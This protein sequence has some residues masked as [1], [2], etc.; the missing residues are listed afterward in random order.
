MSVTPFEGVRAGTGAKAGV[1]EGRKRAP[2][3]N[4]TP[5]AAAAATAAKPTGKER[6]PLLEVTDLDVAYGQVVAIR[7]L[8]MSVAEGEMIALVGANGAGQHPLRRGGDDRPLG[9]SHRPRRHSARA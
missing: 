9:P 7:G 3:T 5:S 6:K 4:A 2:G 1:K 8:T